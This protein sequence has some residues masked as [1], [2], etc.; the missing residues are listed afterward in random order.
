VGYGQ[1]E[2]TNVL[3]GLWGPERILLNDTTHTKLDNVYY[4]IPNH[5]IIVR[6]NLGTV[7][8]AF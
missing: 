4:N 3:Q 5:S 8:S 7:N 6:R 1:G 2:P